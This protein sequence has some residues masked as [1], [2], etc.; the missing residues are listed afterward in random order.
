MHPP[1]SNNGNLRSC[2]ILYHMNKYK[3]INI[4]DN[5]LT[6]LKRSVHAHTFLIHHLC[7]EAAVPELQQSMDL[8]EEMCVSILSFSTSSLVVIALHWIGWQYITNQLSSSTGQIC[9]RPSICVSRCVFITFIVWMHKRVKIKLLHFF[10][11]HFA[12]DEDVCKCIPIFRNKLL[13]LADYIDEYNCSM[14]GGLTTWLTLIFW[15]AFC[16]AHR[17]NQSKITKQTNFIR[18]VIRVREVGKDNTRRLI[19]TISVCFLSDTREKRKK[20]K[21]KE[22]AHGSF[23][24]NGRN[25]RAQWFFMEAWLKR[26]PKAGQT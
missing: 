19:Q 7:D 22:N 8:C 14:L 2:K 6:L 1:L 25:K 11:F 13:S 24:R 20:G 5:D 9:S 18:R 12:A 21:K 15:E 10:F 23:S 4:P 17:K 3:I 26:S 16:D